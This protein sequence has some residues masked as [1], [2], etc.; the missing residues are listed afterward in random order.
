MFCPSL[1][2]VQVAIGVG[3]DRYVVVAGYWTD[4][5]LIDGQPHIVLV[6]VD[7]LGR[8]VRIHVSEMAKEHYKMFI[9]ELFELCG[10]LNYVL[11]NMHY[12]VDLY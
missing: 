7:Q 10:Y 12:S 1:G 3:V 9:V 6:K 2:M 11:L 8:R 5:T 4:D